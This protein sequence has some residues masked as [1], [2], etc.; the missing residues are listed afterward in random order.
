VSGNSNAQRIDISKRAQQSESSESIA[1]LI[2]L[3][4]MNL[5]MIPRRLSVRRELPLQ[6]I[7]HVVSLTGGETSSSTE[8]KKKYISVAGEYRSKRCG[9]REDLSRRTTRSV[10]RGPASV[11]EQNRRVWSAPDRPPQESTQVERAASHH[12]SVW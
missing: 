9:L 12:R 8:K 4:Q 5:K 10:I 7:A 2:G 3:Q 11:I 6:K 1:Q